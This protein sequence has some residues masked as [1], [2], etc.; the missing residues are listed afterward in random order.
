M[1]DK[2]GKLCPIILAGTYGKNDD[3]GECMKN[4]CALWVLDY[5]DPSLD[6]SDDIFVPA[7]ARQGHCGLIKE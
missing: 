6:I 7:S 4:R 1:A 2:R 3:L 5:H